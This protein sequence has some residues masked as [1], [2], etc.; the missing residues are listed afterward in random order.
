LHLDGFEFT[1]GHSTL[2]TADTAIGVVDMLIIYDIH[3]DSP[4]RTGQGAFA[5]KITLIKIDLGHEVRR[6]NPSRHIKLGYPSHKV[7]TAPA[8]GTRGP[9]QFRIPVVNPG[10]QSIGFGLGLDLQGLLQFDRA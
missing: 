2:G 10:D 1:T 4:H 5:A 6:G 8:A 3:R 7:T 9:T